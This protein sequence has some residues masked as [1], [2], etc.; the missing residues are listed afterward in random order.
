MSQHEQSGTAG[1]KLPPG[2]EP[3]LLSFDVYGTL[4]N[5]PPSN[6]EVFRSILVEIFGHQSGPGDLWRVLGTA[7]HLPLF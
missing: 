2:I 4:I 1:P 5:T 7:Q 3:R 6:L